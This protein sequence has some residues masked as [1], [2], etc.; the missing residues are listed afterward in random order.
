MVIAHPGC[1]TI[2]LI[3]LFLP[4]Y[5][6]PGPYNERQKMTWQTAITA[7]QAVLILET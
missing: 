4:E 2:G 1:V 6:E 5:E 3:P 7:C